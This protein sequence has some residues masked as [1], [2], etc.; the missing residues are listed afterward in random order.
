MCPHTGAGVVGTRN[1][2]LVGTQGIARLERVRGRERK[3]SYTSRLRQGHKQ[4]AE[5]E[6][7]AAMPK[8]EEVAR[9]RKKEEEAKAEEKVDKMVE[10]EEELGAGT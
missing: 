10:D 9:K 6:E 4:E 7:E 2:A 3:A 1:G 8:L 5:S